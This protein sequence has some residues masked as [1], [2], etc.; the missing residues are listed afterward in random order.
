[1]NEFSRLNAMYAD[2]LKLQREQTTQRPLRST[3]PRRRTTRRVIA[4]GLHRLADHLDG[5]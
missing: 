4:G 2:D 1:M 3:A 5:E